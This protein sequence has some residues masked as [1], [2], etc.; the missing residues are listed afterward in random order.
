MGAEF[1]DLD[2]DGTLSEREVKSRFE[3]YQNEC[4]HESGNS[5]SGRLNM[6]NGLVFAQVRVFDSQN[7][8]YEYLQNKCQKWENAIAVKYFASNPIKQDDAKAVKLR[9][10]VRLSRDTL[11]RFESALTESVETKLKTVEFIKCNGCKSR[12]D[13]RFRRKTLKCPVCESSFASKTELK[14]R[15]SLK[16]KVESAETKLREYLQKLQAKANTKNRETRWLIGGVC[17]S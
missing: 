16:S 4:A 11:Q 5:Y 12:L 7:E 8:A 1:D 13:T 17:S 2:L 3:A 14:K 6:C 15:E 9:D 10:A